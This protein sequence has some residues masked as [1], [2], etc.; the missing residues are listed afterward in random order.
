LK[1]YTAVCGKGANN[2]NIKHL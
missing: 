1:Q 2:E